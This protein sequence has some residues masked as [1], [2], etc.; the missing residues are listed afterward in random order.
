MDGSA[1]EKEDYV[2]VDEVIVFE[3]GEREKQIEIHIVDDNKWEPDE[4]FF[5]KLSLVNKTENDL[6]QLGRIT[7]ME[8]T[9]MDDDSES[10]PFVR[11]SE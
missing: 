9:I 8:I 6:V 7:I 5:L 3:S 11:F 4:E 1:K 2:P 10:C